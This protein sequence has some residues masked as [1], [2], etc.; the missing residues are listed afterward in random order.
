VP[1]DSV[2]GPILFLIF[3]NDLKSVCCGDYVIMLSSIMLFADDA[4]LYSHIDIDQPFTS[5]QHSP[6]CLSSCADSW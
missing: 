6:D 5:R 3:I 4:K 2:L 1:Q